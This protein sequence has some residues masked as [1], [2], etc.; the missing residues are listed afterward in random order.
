MMLWNILI[1]IYLLLGTLINIALVIS[2]PDVT[3]KVG[4]KIK[5]KGKYLLVMLF[6]WITWPWLVYVVLTTKTKH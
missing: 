3:I 4:G 5:E 6:I 1:I 2:N